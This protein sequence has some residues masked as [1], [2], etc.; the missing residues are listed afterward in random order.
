MTVIYCGLVCL[1]KVYGQTAINLDSGNVYK[2]LYFGDPESWKSENRSGIRFIIN[3]LVGRYN[4]QTHLTSF[5]A[6]GMQKSDQTVALNDEFPNRL[7]FVNV[8]L[9]F[10]FKQ[11]KWLTL[12]LG[13]G[14]T[15]GT[16]KYG[17]GFS[18][19]PVFS[20][21]LEIFLLHAGI[22]F[23]KRYYPYKMNAGIFLEGNFVNYVGIYG[24]NDSTEVVSGGFGNQLVLQGFNFSYGMV[25]GGEYLIGKHL[26]VSL[27]FGFI[28][29]HFETLKKTGYYFNGTINNGII[30]VRIINIPSI[31]PGIGLNYSY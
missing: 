21:S 15:Y 10:S 26:G 28:C 19:R 20:S 6:N 12:D 24:Q 25:T 8:G 30:I 17:N 1:P 9:F 18:D 5:D 27:D 29:F 23:V 31:E 7:P 11:E 13:P 4:E 3:G 2:K 22:N 16:I 14:I